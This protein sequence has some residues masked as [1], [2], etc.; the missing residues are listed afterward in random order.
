[1]WRQEILSCARK[2]ARARGRKWVNRGPFEVVVLLYL[3]EG[4]QYDKHD[5]DN[6]LKDVLDGLQGA[7]YNKERGKHRAQGRIIKN[8]S[9]VCR[10]IV[11]KQYLPKKHKNRES[12]SGGRLI[13]RAYKEGRWPFRIAAGRG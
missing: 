4:K 2:A 10:V 9:S 5:V 7:F 8:D 11:E 1:M 3:T 13:V 12:P 6:R